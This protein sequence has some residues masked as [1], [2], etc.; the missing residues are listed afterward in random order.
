MCIVHP[1]SAG[2]PSPW[3]NI[4]ASVPAYVCTYVHKHINV[5][6]YLCTYTYVLKYVC[7]VVCIPA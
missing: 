2:T 5:N 1:P 4:A 6:Y 7:N 3:Y